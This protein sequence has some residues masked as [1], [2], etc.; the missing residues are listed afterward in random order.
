MCSLV[1]LGTEQLT[2]PSVFG[3]RARV[4]TIVGV[5]NFLLR[6]ILRLLS[7]FPMSAAYPPIPVAEYGVRQQ[8]PLAGY[9]MPQQQQSFAPGYA[10]HPGLVV[11]STSGGD[12]PADG[13]AGP[14]LAYAARTVIVA[15]VFSFFSL[16]F[17]IV[18]LAAPWVTYRSC[19]FND[20]FLTA[21]F[22][23]TVRFC[24]DA[25]LKAA[26]VH[27][28]GFHAMPP[29]PPSSFAVFSYFLHVLPSL[30]QPFP[31]CAVHHNSLGCSSILGVKCFCCRDLYPLRLCRAHLHQRHTSVLWRRV[32]CFGA[33]KLTKP[34]VSFLAQ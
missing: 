10:P 30:C 15:V 25:F 11:V 26:R 31:V 17:G 29:I 32:S 2:P 4:S 6:Y 1:S 28:L 21:C 13:L 16:I 27:L 14:K 19:N 8:N 7:P 20:D 22:S 3:R 34:P 18:A 24:D 9:A 12:G 23:Y 33:F 5:V